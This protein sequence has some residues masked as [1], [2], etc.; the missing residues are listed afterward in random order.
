MGD[1]NSWNIDDVI[2]FYLQTRNPDTGDAQDADATPTYRIYEDITGTPIL[3]GS[4]SLLD[5]SNTDGFY[6][7]QITLSAANGFENG[8]SYCMRSVAVV[9]SV[10]GAQFDTFQLG[11]PQ[12]LTAAYDAAKTAASQTTANTIA[13]YVDTEVAAIKAQTDKMSFD[14][15]NRIASNVTAVRAAVLSAKVGTNFDF[16]FQD[17][18]ADTTVVVDN[19]VTGGTGPTA[20]QIAD[21]VWDEA[22]SGHTTAGTF[23]KTDADELADAVAI[24][25]K[26]DN[27]PTDPADAS[28]IVTQF[29]TVNTTL[30]TIDA[31]ID[32]EI[33]AIKAKTDLIPAT[34]AA[35]GSAMTLTSAYDAAKTAAT[36]TSVDT[37]AGY[38]DTEVAAIKAKT[39]QLVFTV[40]NQLNVNMLSTVGQLL[41]NKVGININTFFQNGGNNTA[42]IVDNTAAVGSGVTDWTAGERQQI[43]YR[44]GI[45]GS[46]ATPA[47]TPTIPVTLSAAYDPAKTA[48]QAGD[49][50]AL[51][52][53][54]R[55]TLIN[56]LLDLAN[57]I[58]NGLTPRNCMRLL[59][60]AVYSLATGMDTATGIFKSADI[61]ANAIVG[62]KS[63]ITATGLSNTGNRPAIVVDLT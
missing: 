37:V 11:R 21:A 34:P 30:A 42:S 46:V 31:R 43:R 47:A 45:D 35:V 2:T 56:A 19:V 48:A 51:T 18:G 20:A 28:D 17:A 33:P 6:A 9:L 54:E 7:R 32:T 57:G 61:S 27:L 26:T 59:S 14:A 50:M 22:V 16:F 41:G 15:A 12:L 60:A 55:T 62:T 63:R 38:V 24:K 44:L 52:S 4:Y 53:G 10:T 8:K 3:T 23:G 39:D 1:Y 58:E 5:S 36:Q 40:A 13:G 29:N 49:A 25:A